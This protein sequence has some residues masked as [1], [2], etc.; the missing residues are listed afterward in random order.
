VIFKL[1]FKKVAKENL[2]IVLSSPHQ[3]KASG[4]WGRG[5]KDIAF[6]GPIVTSCEG[7]NQIKFTD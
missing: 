4:K 1:N 5:G 2:E 6:E 3:N 7:K